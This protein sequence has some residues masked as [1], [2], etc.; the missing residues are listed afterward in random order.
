MNNTTRVLMVIWILLVGANMYMLKKE[1]EKSR[2]REEVIGQT[3]KHFSYE[4]DV[5]TKATL[6]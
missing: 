3:L 2:Q 1:I 5:L 4:L 6:K